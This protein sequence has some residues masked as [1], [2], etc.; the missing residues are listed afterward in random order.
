MGLLRSRSFVASPMLAAAA[1]ATLLLVERRAPETLPPVRAPATAPAPAPRAP[2]LDAMAARLAKRLEGKDR[3]DGEGW[4]L[5]ARAYVELHRHA[6][7]AA[8]FDR[9]RAI[10][11]D[12]AEAR[13][14][15]GAPPEAWMPMVARKPAR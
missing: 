7:A 12:I 8:A 1:V 5:L 11:A 4:T 2:G 10:E 6:E 15:S 14:L 13:A 3:D 9:A